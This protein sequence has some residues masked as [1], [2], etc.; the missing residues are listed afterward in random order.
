MENEP[1]LQPGDVLAALLATDPRPQKRKNLQLIDRLCS[2]QKESGGVISVKVIGKL[3]EAAGGIKA[4]ALYNAPSEDYRTLIGAWAGMSG[5]REQSAVWEQH[6]WTRY[7]RR[8]DDLALRSIVQQAFVERDRLLAE[9]KLL[10]SVTMLQIDRRPQGNAASTEAGV[11]ESLVLTES[12]KA[13]LERAVQA[14]FLLDEGWQEGK[15]GEIL[16]ERGRKIFDI[17]FTHA[18][19]RVLALVT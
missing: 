17:G 12:E 15:S 6:S 9:L 11:S 5:V 19:R 7:I 1:E 3:S 16:N 8:I 4:R 2:A 18:I 13:A 10:K 14:A